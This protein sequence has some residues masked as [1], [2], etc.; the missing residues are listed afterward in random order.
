MYGTVFDVKSVPNPINVAY[1]SFELP[2]HMDL[3]Y[4]IDQWLYLF[5]ILANQLK[6]T[7]T[8]KRRLACSCFTACDLTKRLVVKVHLL[9]D[10]K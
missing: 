1:T 8:M 3:W 6:S 2:P 4:E 9:M 10:F 7:V 5:G